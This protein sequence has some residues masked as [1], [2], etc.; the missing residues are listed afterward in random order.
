MLVISNLSKVSPLNNG[1]CEREWVRM[2]G[3]TKSGWSE[4]HHKVTYICTNKV[5]FVSN[6]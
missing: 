1:V 3:V 2:E 4:E 6:L 5:T